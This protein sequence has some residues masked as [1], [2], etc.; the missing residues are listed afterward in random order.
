MKIATS[1][2]AASRRQLGVALGLAADIHGAVRD[3]H[4]AEP[5]RQAALNCCARPRHRHPQE[6]WQLCSALKAT[7]PR[8][9]A[10]AWRLADG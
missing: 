7:A 6:R 2:G 1:I 10:N 8:G 3:G 4:R 5:R 9:A